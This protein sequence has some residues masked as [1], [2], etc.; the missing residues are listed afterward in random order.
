MADGG[1]GVEE[2]D[3]ATACD[4]LSMDRDQLDLGF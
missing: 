1:A 3:A 4:G 2:E